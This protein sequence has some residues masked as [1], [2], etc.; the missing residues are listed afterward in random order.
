MLRIHSSLCWTLVTYMQCTAVHVA[1]IIH[2]STVKHFDHLLLVVKG[3]INKDWLILALLPW[4]SSIYGLCSMISCS[5][6]FLRFTLKSADRPDSVLAAWIH[7]LSASDKV[8]GGWL[9]WGLQLLLILLFKTWIMVFH[10][11]CTL[12][13]VFSVWCLNAQGS[14]VKKVSCDL[15]G[16]Y[17][18]KL[19]LKKILYVLYVI[20]PNYY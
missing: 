13:N 20:G 4:G 12:Y 9:D 14:S 16:I 1:C 17:L 18:V 15:N 7:R 5:R 2:C 6:S 19:R 10:I 3:C 11:Y 8:F